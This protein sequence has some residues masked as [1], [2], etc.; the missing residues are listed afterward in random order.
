M[1]SVSDAARFT[2][3][4]ISTRKFK[5][6]WEIVLDYL[7]LAI[8]LLTIFSWAKV[9]SADASGL[10]CIPVNPTIR[11]NFNLAKYFN[12]RCAQEF[13]KKLLLYYP[14]V[15]FA[16][17]LVLSIVQKL[18][19]K[20]PVVHKKFETF[21]E[22]LKDMRNMTEEEGSANGNSKQ[23]T[24]FDKL[25]LVLKNKSYLIHI[26]TAKASLLLAF[27][28]CIFCLTVTWVNSLN[29]FQANFKCYLG[30]P[31]YSPIRHLACNFQP[32]EFLYVI[33]ACNIAVQSSIVGL[34]SYILYWILAKQWVL[35][36]G[37]A[38]FA[39]FRSL[40]GYKDLCFCIGLAK[41]SVQEKNAIQN[42]MVFYT[43]KFTNRGKYEKQHK[44]A[45]NRKTPDDVTIMTACHSHDFV[46]V[47]YVCD[48]LGLVINASNGTAQQRNRSKSLTNMEQILTG[49]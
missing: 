35:Q 7:I 22:L 16:Q 49:R 24:I 42:S 46:S 3:E 44:G 48:H 47:K 45:V 31:A 6:W 11:Y 21:Y 19:L 20:L 13:E 25:L 40:G 26:Y 18:W 5:P 36:T 10:L 15:L 28:L 12:S 29:F 43:S 41:T 23:D 4:S 9:I 1:I 37:A 2:E 33:I 38:N 8:L 39:S 32:A 17:W 30:G 14:Y 27:S 34:S